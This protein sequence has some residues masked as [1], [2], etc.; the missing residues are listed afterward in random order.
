MAEPEIEHNVIR[1]TFD[2]IL[3]YRSLTTAVWRHKLRSSHLCAE[4]SVICWVVS[5]VG[6]ALYV[7][8]I[9]MHC[10]R[11]Q[12]INVRPAVSFTQ[13]AMFAVTAAVNA[14]IDQLNEHNKSD[15]D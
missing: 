14:L 8:T 6:V 12:A 10:G 4:S 1:R 13:Y 2:P 3:A 9:T 7:T 11:T 15:C 5:R